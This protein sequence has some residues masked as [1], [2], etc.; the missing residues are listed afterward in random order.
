MKVKSIVTGLLGTVALLYAVNVGE[1]L[2]SITLEKKD[3][4][5]SNASA[6]HSKSLQ[7]K[8]H[9]LLYMD[10][11]E[12]ETVNPFLDE[13][14]AQSYDEKHYS[15]VAIV[16]LA[17]MWMPDFVLETMLKK[18][19]EELKNTTFVFDKT[20]YLVKKWK[21]K[22]DASNVLI[23]DKQMKVLYQKSTKLSSSDIAEI[24]EILSKETRQ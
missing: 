8:V 22:D 24:M 6:W 16:N 1:V 21:M 12:R 13:L 9:V 4:G 2:P 19:Q 11:D 18:K 23:V 14:N 10:P 17:A 15:T 7:G 3:G 5:Q 20:K